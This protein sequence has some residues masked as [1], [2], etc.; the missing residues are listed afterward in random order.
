MNKDKDDVLDNG[1]MAIADAAK[2]CG[3]HETTVRAWIR[4]GHIKSARIVGRHRAV[5][6]EELRAYNNSERV[7]RERELMKRR[8]KGERVAPPSQSDLISRLEQLIARLESILGK[9][10]P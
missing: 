7:A 3:C 9:D 1:W 8:L 6:L 10:A 5:R 2:A 4:A